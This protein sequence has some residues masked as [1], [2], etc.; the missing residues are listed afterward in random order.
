MERQFSGEESAGEA[1]VTQWYPISVMVFR[2]QRR[3]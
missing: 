2:H 3:I 1:K